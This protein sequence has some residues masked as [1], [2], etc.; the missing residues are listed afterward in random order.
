MNDAFFSVLLLQEQEKSL[1]SLKESLTSKLVLF[2]SQVKNGI[3]VE[4]AADAIEAELKKTEQSLVD[5]KA[6]RLATLAV[7]GEFVGYTIPAEMPLVL[8]NAQAVAISAERNKRPE[9]KV[10]SLTKE[11]LQN[12]RGLTSSEYLPKLSAYFQYTYGRPSLNVFDNTFQA[13][14]VAGVKA[15]WT[16]WNWNQS[17][18]QREIYEIQQRQTE[19]EEQTF[20]KNLKVSVKHDLSDIEKI[21][22]L[23]KMDEEIISLRQKIVKQSSSQLD[24]GVIT[25]TDYLTELTAKTQAELMLQ[26]HKIQLVRAK[27]Q[28]LTKMGEDL[29]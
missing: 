24:N 16:L 25:A 23:I 29:K 18:R 2:R 6:N 26:T 28:Y 7:L 1:N 17:G 13:Y 20:T 11:Q 9:Y 14:Y 4:S 12:Y 19:A 15:S 8:P 27:V 3:S 21:E 10:F 22:T 5:V